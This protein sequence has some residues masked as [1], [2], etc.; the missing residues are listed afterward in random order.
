L[1]SLTKTGAR[2]GL[3]AGYALGAPDLLARLAAARP[4]WPV[5]TLVLE[6]VRVCSAPAAV[7][8]AVAAAAQTVRHREWMAHQLADLPG[9]WELE[10]ISVRLWPGAT[11]VQSLLTALLAWEAPLIARRC[12]LPLGTSLL[13]VARKAAKTVAAPKVA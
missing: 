13:V 9:V 6:A 3:R 7:A 10:Q 5:G 11:P 1:G 8:E 4:P 2:P 12:P